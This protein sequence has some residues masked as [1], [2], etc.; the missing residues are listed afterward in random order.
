MKKCY[1][2][3][4][5]D[6]CRRIIKDLQ[7]REHDFKFQDIKNRPNSVSELEQWRKS[8]SSYS[9]LFNRR[10]RKYRS[11][12]LKDKEL[13]EDQIKEWILKEYTFLK[14]PVIVF[15]NHLFIGNSKKVIEEAKGVLY[16]TK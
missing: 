3:S 11:E 9:D 14:R 15:G 6:T 4:T 5:C 12:G 2:L 10:A 13:S 8:V 16:E 1:Y 7:L